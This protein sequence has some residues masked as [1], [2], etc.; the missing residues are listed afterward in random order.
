MATAHSRRAIPSITPST[1]SEIIQKNK[2]K[3]CFITGAGVSTE[4]G[5][6]DYRGPAGRY[7]QTDSKPMTHQEFMGDDF[8]RKRYWSRAVVGFKSFNTA[9]PNRSHFV[10]AELGRS[11]FLTGLITQ[12]VD[13]LHH[14]AG[15]HKV[16]ELHGRG[17]MVECMT[18]GHQKPREEYHKELIEE[19][20]RWMKSIENKS[21]TL[22][23][24][25]DAVI[26]ESD[27]HSFC[28]LNCDVCSVGILKPSFVFFGGIVPPD[29]SESALDLVTNCNALFLI[30]S[31]A[32]T[33]SCYRLIKAARDQGAYVSIINKGPTRVDDLAHSVFDTDSCGEFLEQVARQLLPNEY[34]KASELD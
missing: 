24:D 7:L 6:P 3:T 30:G 10:I 4:S 28:V 1:A 26:D 23:A 25:G 13:R 15:S 29:V 5:L 34:G 11:R 27:V 16:I 21:Y 12:N 33:F 19:N 20:Q 9:K 2:H 22:T 14:R 18:C 8:N 31:T 17:D 32:S